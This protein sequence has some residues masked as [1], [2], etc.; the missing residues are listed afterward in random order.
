MSNAK[1]HHSDK[2][3]LS[4]VQIPFCVRRESRF[5]RNAYI[6]ANHIVSWCDCLKSGVEVKKVDSK[7][8]IVL[9]ADCCQ[10][11]IEESRELYIFRRK[12]Y[13]KIIP[14]RRIDLTESF[15]KV[16]LGIESIGNW[17][18]FEKNPF[19]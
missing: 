3:L 18:E 7:G 4:S 14:K 9:P 13:L 11:E 8:C 15:D 16:D 17:K 12:G 5:G 10:T 19:H 6:I 2:G 1:G